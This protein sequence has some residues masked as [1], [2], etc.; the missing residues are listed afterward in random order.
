VKSNETEI[1]M[2]EIDMDMDEIDM[3]MDDPHILLVIIMT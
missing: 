1:D 3:D 2:D